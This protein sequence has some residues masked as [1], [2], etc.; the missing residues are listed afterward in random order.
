[1]KIHLRVFMFPKADQLHESNGRNKA[2]QF[3]IYSCNYCGFH[4]CV[5]HNTNRQPGKRLCLL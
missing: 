4:K 3:S 1:M 2:A 5:I